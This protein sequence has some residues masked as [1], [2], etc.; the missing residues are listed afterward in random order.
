MKKTYETGLWGEDTAKSYLED[1]CGMSCLEHRYRTKCG[2]IDLI[3]LDKDYIVFIEV[4]TRI[5][6]KPG[7][8][9]E[10]VNRRKQQRIAKA[11]TLYLMQHKMLN[12]A[13]RFDVIEVRD[14]EFLYIPNAFQPGG[15]FYR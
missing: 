12:H 8:G 2:E 9:L 1:E 10:S 7:C 14:D 4:K 13:I 6:G 3:M 15:M 5:S 11:A